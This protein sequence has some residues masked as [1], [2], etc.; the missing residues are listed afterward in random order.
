VKE[1]GVH[2]ALQAKGKATLVEK[3]KIRIPKKG[4]KEMAPFPSKPAP[5]MEQKKHT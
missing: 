5:E 2:P 3:R 1:E 4:K